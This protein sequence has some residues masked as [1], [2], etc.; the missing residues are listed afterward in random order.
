MAASDLVAG[1]VMDMA[2]SMMN[3]T[4]K[5]V[6]TYAAQVPYLQMAM[7]ELREYFELHNISVTQEVS[8]VIPI[9][10]GQTKIVYNG[11]TTPALPSDFVEPIRLWERAR[12]IDPYTP[13]VRVDFIPLSLAGI[14]TNY[15][16]YFTWNGQEITFPASNADNDIKMD[17]LRELFAPVVDQTS[18][19]NVVN[20]QSFL[21]YRTAGLLAE[22][23][24]RNITSANSL[25]QNAVLALDRAT[26][27]SAKSKQSIMTRRRPFR[28][29][30]K[31]GG[32]S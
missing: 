5:T 10:A 1:T 28:G 14:Q 30:Y 11:T 7:R 4:A 24:E 20:A 2:A 25:N 32:W 29:S 8:A 17:Y 3:D 18:I 16:G 9:N 23:I 19:I 26:G 6:Y 31:R 13:M 21:Q 15:F 12:G 27:I 22:F